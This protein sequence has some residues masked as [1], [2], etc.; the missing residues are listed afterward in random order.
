MDFTS[1]TQT[2]GRH[3]VSQSH[4]CSRMG[5]SSHVSSV[6]RPRL[7]GLCGDDVRLGSSGLLIRLHTAYSHQSRRGPD[8][9]ALAAGVRPRS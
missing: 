5:G 9:S 6:H 3:I 8:S 4:P 1:G 7:P 2:L